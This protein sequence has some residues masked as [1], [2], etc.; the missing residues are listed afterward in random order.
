MERSVLDNVVEGQ[1][2]IN[3]RR[4]AQKPKSPI[5]DTSPIAIRKGNNNVSGGNVMN[6]TRPS[7]PNR[8]IQ[9]DH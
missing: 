7:P 3:R 2:L 1:E 6:Q 9:R 4:Q 5:R 8:G